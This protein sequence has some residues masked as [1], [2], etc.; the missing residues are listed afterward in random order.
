[1]SELFKFIKEQRAVRRSLIFML[2]KRFGVG[3]G[4][5]QEVRKALGFK[6]NTLPWSTWLYKNEA[7]LAKICTLVMRRRVLASRLEDVLLEY[8]SHLA[9]INCYRHARFVQ[10]LPGRGQRTRTNAQTSKRRPVPGQFIGAERV[11]VK[12]L[13]KKRW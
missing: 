1:M 11:V 8:R 3:I 10:Q 13:S 6:Q 12:R 7:V 9:R 4:V 2:S 5:L